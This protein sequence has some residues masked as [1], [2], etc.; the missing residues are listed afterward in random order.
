MRRVRLN[1]GL[2]LPPGTKGK[3]L[4]E[5]TE[6][7]EDDLAGL[8]V[9]ALVAAG[10]VEE[11]P[12]DLKCPACAENG[13]AAQKKKTYASHAELRS[14]YDDEHIALQAPTESEV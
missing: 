8:N 4:E 9:N 1:V 7:T 12:R 5:G 2:Q 3:Y 13:T 10:F 11:M 14:H 6:A